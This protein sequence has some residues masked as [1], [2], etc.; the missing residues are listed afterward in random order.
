MSDSTALAAD[1]ERIN[2]QL[3]TQEQIYGSQLMTPQEREEHRTM[4][5]T[6]KTSEEQEQIRI[7]HHERMKERASELGVTLEG[8][9]P[10]RGMRGGMG[11]GGSN[12]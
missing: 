8:A 2:A 9:P 6:A 11:K 5:R 4:M 12:R 10:E 1:Q 3:E 7:E